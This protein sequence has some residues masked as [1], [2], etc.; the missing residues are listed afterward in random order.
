MGTWPFGSS[1]PS[2]TRHDGHTPAPPLPPQ[3]SGPAGS[4]SND[5][6][7]DNPFIAFRRAV[8]DHF[9]ILATGLSTI[10]SILHDLQARGESDPTPSSSD[11]RW[12]HDSFAARAEQPLA[13]LS[14][15]FE[16]PTSHDAT[17]PSDEAL[18]ATR[19]LLLQS[20]TACANAGVHPSSIMRLYRDADSSHPF[21][22][23]SE[24]AWLSVRWFRHSPYSP[25]QLETHPQLHQQGSMWRAAFEDLLSTSTGRAPSAHDAWTGAHPDQGLYAAWAQTPRD[26]MLGLQCRGVLPPQLPGLYRLGCT[27]QMDG[28]FG[29]LMSGRGVGPWGEAARRDFVELAREVGT[30]DPDEQPRTQL[31]QKQQEQEQEHETELDAYEHFLGKASSGPHKQADVPARAP[32]RTPEDRTPPPVAQIE[33]QIVS[34]LSTTER[35]TLPDGTVTTKVVLRKRFADGREES[36]E[37]V[38]TTMGQQEGDGRVADKEEA[39]KEQKK[40]GWFWS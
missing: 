34:T 35:T 33:T 6:D 16:P 15:H 13:F 21:A 39:K 12:T 20:R 7:D 18:S 24:H 23:S 17:P 22:A 25:G 5:D 4:N 10:P 26:W 11:S 8:D 14:Q 27:R 29:R 30:V 31:S 37:S 19:V 40:K 9:R 2:S 1:A 3:S 38:S 28:V 36:T 32:E